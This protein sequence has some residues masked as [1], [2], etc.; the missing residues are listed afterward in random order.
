MNEHIAKVAEAKKLNP[1]QVARVCEAANLGTYHAMW[2]K[3]G[4]GDFTFDLADQDKV[5][6]K[7]ASPSSPMLDEYSS[8]PCCLKDLL[9]T[10]EEVSK[11][12]KDS[13][14]DTEKKAAAFEK[15][16]AAVN[17]EADVPLPTLMKLAAKMK[18][19]IKEIES[20]QFESDVMRKEAVLKL[21]DA[22]KTAALKDENIAK[23]Y[24]AA[25]VVLS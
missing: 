1:H 17:A 18:Y 3:V 22:L 14:K 20:A 13:D 8:D 16:A 2:D 10:D 21:R 12:K 6:E 15:T 19:Y 24:A 7:L 25:L 4:S 11:I 9:P 23:A 5:A